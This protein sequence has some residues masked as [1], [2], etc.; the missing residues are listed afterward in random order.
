ISCIMQ[1]I[2]IDYKFFN[3]S[4][5]IHKLFNLFIILSTASLI[6]TEG[7]DSWVWDCA[8]LV[9]SKTIAITR[10]TAN[11][12]GNS[13]RSSVGRTIVQSHEHWDPGV[14]STRRLK[15]CPLQSR[16]CE[17]RLHEQISTLV[18]L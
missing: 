12:C 4:S 16:H 2:S 14:R 5:Q 15:P 18:L 17:S 10:P 9:P 6:G 13:K 8:L 3:Y 1:Y 11:I 7:G